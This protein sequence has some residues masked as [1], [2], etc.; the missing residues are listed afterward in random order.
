MTNQTP[1]RVFFS[2]MSCEAVYSATQ[3]RKPSKFVGRFV[4]KGCKTTVHRRWSSQYSFLNWMGPI[5]L[6]A[7]SGGTVQHLSEIEGRPRSIV[8]KP[9]RRRRA[10]G[11]NR[12]FSAGAVSSRAPSR[13]RRGLCQ[14]KAPRWAAS[15]ASCQPIHS[16]GTS[17]W[18][19][20]GARTDP[21]GGGGH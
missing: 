7:R 13:C 5:Q 6:R 19:G 20:V 8:K 21:A 14:Q 12:A 11:L 17:Q 4:C 1:L 9:N 15:G 10:G 18:T 16:V 3:E 2:C